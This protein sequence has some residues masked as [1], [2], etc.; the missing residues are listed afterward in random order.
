[1]QNE[2]TEKTISI[3][4]TIKN[5][6]AAELSARDKLATALANLQADTA[7]RRELSAAEDDK[8]TRLVLDRTALIEKGAA[9][10][11]LA[12]QVAESHRFSDQHDG[13][14]EANDAAI[15]TRANELNLAEI[16]L[17]QMYFA[18][19][20]KQR[21][22]V[23]K[24][25]AALIDTLME[26]VEAWQDS[27]QA[28]AVEMDLKFDTNDAEWQLPLDPHP[29]NF[30][31]MAGFVPDDAAVDLPV[32]VSHSVPAAIKAAETKTEAPETKPTPKPSMQEMTA[33][34]QKHD[35]RSGNKQSIA[36]NRG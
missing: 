28:L 5:A 11:S 19:V 26:A 33:W 27:Y 20:L 6:V 18:A 1:M 16:V 34:Q 22:A 21:P 15:A 31:R 13:A 4:D 3:A 8:R 30:H 17:K 32:E 7:K 14:I 9:G 10:D 36:I 24:Q 23:D 25:I 35:A 29:S 2:K 12:R